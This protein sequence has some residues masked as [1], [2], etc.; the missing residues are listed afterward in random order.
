MDIALGG[1]LDISGYGGKLFTAKPLDLALTTKIDGVDA[2]TDEGKEVLKLV[3]ARWVVEMETFRKTQEKTYKEILKE[4]ENNVLA[5]LKK[6]SPEFLQKAGGDGRNA[7]ELA[8]AWMTEEAKGA[9]V[10]IANALRTFEGIVEKKA[11]EIWDAVSKQVDKK[12]K[13]ILKKAKFAAAAKITGLAILIVGAAA[14]TV[15]ASVFAALAAPTG[16]G[17]VAGVGLALGG[18]ATVVAAA[19]KIYD[20]YSANWP[21]HKTAAGDV[22]KSAEA[23]K[24]ALEYEEKKAAKVSQG[25]TLGPKEKAKLFFGNTK[26]KRKDLEAAITRLSVFTVT[27]MQDIEK[28]AKAEEG[29]AAKLD[30][31]DKAMAKETDKKKLADMKKVSDACV[32]NIFDSRVKR[33]NARLYLKR[34]TALA[35]EGQALVATEDKLTPSAV[36]GFLATLADLA[37]SKE[38]EVLIDY[39][40]AGAELFKAL[41][42]FTAK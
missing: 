14:M 17:T 32:K 1:T 29:L 27:M 34:Y 25:A 42:K 15:A 2:A 33:E 40:K 31:L 30:E 22:K 20:V 35:A 41:L 26:G 6:R 21:D 8:V 3:K 11:E 7:A 5:T 37:G 19:K 9:N 38:V 23:L 28:G 10:M 39:G 18:I 12:F 4:T 13:D 36:G 16:V 24:E